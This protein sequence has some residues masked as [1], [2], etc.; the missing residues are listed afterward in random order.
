HWM[1]PGRGWVDPV[2]EKKGVILGLDAGISTMEQEVAESMGADWEE[3]VDQ[4][5]FEINYFKEKGMPPPSWAQANVM[6]P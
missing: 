3:I 1:G 2:A 4:R 5:S 6:A